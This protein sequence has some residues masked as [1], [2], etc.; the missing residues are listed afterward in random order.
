MTTNMQFLTIRL[1]EAES[2][3]LTRLCERTGLS[4]PQIIKR[5]LKRLYD[6]H[7]SSAG[8]S[9]FE[10]GVDR[11]GRYSSKARQSA[12]IKQVIRA[13]LSSRNR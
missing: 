1:S 8:T 5:A 11:F 12:D 2:R 7:L 4:K 3:L 9:L 10:M 13:R 6:E